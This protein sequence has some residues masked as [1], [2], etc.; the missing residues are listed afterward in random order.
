MIIRLTAERVLVPGGLVGPAAVVIDQGRVIDVEP[1]SG[2]VDHH[3]LAP[4]FVDLQVNGVD[5]VDVAR[6]DDELQWGR[7]DRLLLAQGT[8]TWCPTLVT[9]PLERYARPLDRIAAAMQRAPRHRPT[10]AG[11]HLEGPFLGKRVGAHRSD[12]IRPID[13]DWLATLPAHVAMLT[14]GA[15]IEGAARAAAL[16]SARGMLVSIGHTA[17]PHRSVVDVLTS[18]A[19]MATHLFNA[20]TGLDHRNPGV[21]SSILAHPTAAASLIADGVHVHPRMI[22]LACRLLG[23]ERTVLVTDS[24]AWRSATVGPVRLEVR[25]GA[26]RLADGTLAGSAL[27]MDRAVANCVAAGV[28][29]DHALGAASTI[30]ARLL[31]LSDRGVLEAGRRADVVALD[32]S[33]RAVGTWIAGELVSDGT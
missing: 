7:L 15:E 2:P 3:L 30:P 14:L 31:G 29:L 32:A 12:F 8:T 1:N 33:Y 26:P 6:A 19:S 5:D 17:A 21:A 9:M 11:A 20:M 27:T 13:D 23:P 4:G 24:V 10:I 25:D 16:L 18:G 22:D 28:P